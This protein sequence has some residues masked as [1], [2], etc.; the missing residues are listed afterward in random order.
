[1][2]QNQYK[3]HFC[4]VCNGCGCISELPGMGGF[5]ENVNFKLNCADWNVLAGKYSCN[6]G[7]THAAFDEPCGSGAEASLPEIR[8]APVTG[9]VENVGYPDEKQ[10][11]FDLIEAA[12]IAGVKLSIG[13]GCPDEKLLYGI[14][15]L[16]QNGRSAAVF[17]KP[18]PQLRFF[19]RMEWAYPVAEYI[20]IDIDSFNIVTMRNKVNL[21]KKTES[22]LKELKAAA[23]RQGIPFAVKGV[24]TEAD[25]ALMEAVLPDVIVVSNHGGRVENEIGSTAAFLEKN[26]SRLKNCCGGLWVDG[27][28]RNASHLK[29]AGMFG[30]SEVMLGRPLITGLCRDGKD[31][32]K[33][34]LKAFWGE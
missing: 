6:V 2:N 19:E 31:G 12:C 3:C 29:A 26:S 23:A 25:I 15:A 24:F 33:N 27:G 22:Q 21:E 5:A 16:K 10:F 9:A 8:L 30:V 1:M 14:E 11:Y 17:I 4:A 18:Y 28:I 13:D 7:M 34:T 20:G 32:M